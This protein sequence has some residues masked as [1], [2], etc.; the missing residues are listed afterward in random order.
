MAGTG[1]AGPAFPCKPRPRGNT[2]INRNEIIIKAE[3]DYKKPK[4]MAN[5]FIINKASVCFFGAEKGGGT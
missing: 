3:L 4:S 1:V 5:S 2:W